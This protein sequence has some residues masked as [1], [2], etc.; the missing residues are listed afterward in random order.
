MLRVPQDQGQRVPPVP[1]PGSAQRV[2]R[3]VQLG[4]RREG[5]ALEEG[6]TPRG[7]ARG[8]ARVSVARRCLHGRC[9]CRAGA[10]CRE[11]DGRRVM[12]GGRGAA[13]AGRRPGGGLPRASGASER[14]WRVPA[15]LTDPRRQG[16]GGR[17]A[18]LSRGPRPRARLRSASRRRRRRPPVVTAAGPPGWEGAPATR[19]GADRA[20]RAPAGGAPAGSRVRSTPTL[21]VPGPPGRPAPPAPAQTPRTRARPAGG[22]GLPAGGRAERGGASWRAPA[23]PA[24]AAVAPRTSTFPGRSAISPSTVLL[25]AR[26][27]VSRREGEWPPRAWLGLPA[28]RGGPGSSGQRARNLLENGRRAGWKAQHPAGELDLDHFLLCL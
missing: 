11:G 12:G 2:R 9:T 8:E 1:P 10:G 16:G 14:A 24:A 28:G 7:S 6:D 19:G 23:L 26:V 4:G 22:A 5:D 15:A 13:T 25:W 21:R 20:A 27:P 3:R 17:R 18:A